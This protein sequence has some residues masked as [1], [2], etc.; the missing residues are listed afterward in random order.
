MTRYMTLA[1]AVLCCGAPGLRADF[2]YQQSS[3]ITGGAMASAM[4]MVGVFSRKARQPMRST[5]VVKGDRMAQIDEQ[6]AQIIDLQA[7]S[8]TNVNFKKKQYSVVT[9]EQ[10]RQFLAK[11]SRE[12]GSGRGAGGESPQVEL[13]VSVEETGNRKSVSGMDAREFLMTMELEGSDQQTGQSGTMVITMRSWMADEPAG[14]EQVRDFNRRLGQKLHWTP[15][16]ATGAFTRGNQGAAAGMSQIH[17]EMA[18]LEGM[19][20]VQVMTTALKGQEQPSSGQQP[21]AASGQQQ[22]AE[23]PGGAISRGLGSLGGLGR[24]GRK[25]KQA[26]ERQPPAAGGAPGALMEMTIEFSGF[27]NATVDPARVDTAPSGFKR[28]VSE[29]EKALRN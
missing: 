1:A 5:V 24:F 11:M 19:P 2:T 17:E 7:E 28:V 29:V 25:K 8:I 26:P 14:Y 23:P 13:D 16:S 10:M 20:V 27:S 22:E 9:F 12:T 15:G 3:Q 21:A 6:T 4:K 18:K